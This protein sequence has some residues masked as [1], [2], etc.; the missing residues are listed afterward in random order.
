MKVDLSEGRVVEVR[1]LGLGDIFEITDICS[2]V[3]EEGLFK[4]EFLVGLQL[5][6]ALLFGAVMMSGLASG[7]KVVLE[8]CNSLVEKPEEIYLGDWGP[9]FEA[10]WNGPDLSGFLGSLRRIAA[11]Q[12]AAQMLERLDPEMEAE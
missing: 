12:I 3:Y 4:K 10:L 1:R 5:T 9:I 8:W 6:P 2:K 11:S 7:K